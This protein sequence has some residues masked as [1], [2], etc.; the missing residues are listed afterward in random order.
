MV[1]QRCLAVV[2]MLGHVLS[3]GVRAGIGSMLLSIYASLKTR[4]KVSI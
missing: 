4:Y 1:V 2:G 3:R